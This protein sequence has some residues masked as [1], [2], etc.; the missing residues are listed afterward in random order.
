VTPNFE[1]LFYVPNN[2]G[3]AAFRPLAQPWRKPKLPEF[4]KRKARIAVASAPADDIWRDGQYPAAILD[5]L[6]KAWEVKPD[7]VLF[8]ENSIRKPSHPDVQKGLQDISH[9]AA[10]HRC[11]VAVGGIGDEKY[12]NGAARIWDRSGAVV[13]TQPIY[14]TTGA[15]SLKVVD[16]DFARI[17]AHTCGDL[18][19]FP[20]DRVLALQSAELILDPSQMWGPDGSHNELLLRA[21]AIDNGCYLACA[22]WNTSD[23]GLRSVIVDPYGGLVASSGFQKKGIIFADIDFSEGK[24]YYSGLSPK[25]PRPEKQDIANYFTPDLPGISLGWR[26]MIFM[27]RRPELYALIPTENDVTRRY[28]SKELQKKKRP[29]SGAGRPGI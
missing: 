28:I 22:H 19:T 1:N 8:S 18:F 17:A 29:P 9:W 20:I 21:R 25:Q 26:D 6:D 24:V 16:T 2:G 11:Y 14:W 23:P 15:E 27:N 5:L 10:A 7:L 12:P 4:K 3:R 13:Y